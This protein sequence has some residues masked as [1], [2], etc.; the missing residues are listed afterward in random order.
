MAK[1]KALSKKHN[2][3]SQFRIIFSKS[4]LIRWSIGPPFS[5]QRPEHAFSMMQWL[6]EFPPWE[7]FPSIAE[8]SAL[9]PI[10]WTSYCIPQTPSLTTS[11]RHD[12]PS[13]LC[14]V[15]GV[16]SHPSQWIQACLHPD[17]LVLS[18][19]CETE[20]HLVKDKK[21]IWIKHTT[22]WLKIIVQ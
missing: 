12:S 3:H 18:Y 6:F 17:V 11:P 20:P 2:I 7:F 14:R 5:W 10:Q 4:H 13:G 9:V 1:S 16:A 15:T 8:F 22:V 21:I 19:L